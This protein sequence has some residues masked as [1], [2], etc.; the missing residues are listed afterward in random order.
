MNQLEDYVTT[1]KL[2]WETLLER[3]QVQYQ[4]SQEL[5]ER[6]VMAYSSPDRYYHNLKHIQQVLKT[7]EE[8]QSLANNFS[9]IQLAAWFHD[10]IYDS[11]AN[12]NEEKSAAH[13]V[14]ELN[15]LKI[16]LSTIETVKKIILTTKEHQANPDDIDSQILL[17]ADISILG[18]PQLVYRAYAEA[19]RQE[20][21][22]VADEQ[23]KISRKQVLEN[24]LQRERIY[25]TDK[26]F[27]ELEV[28][29]RCNLQAE[30]VFL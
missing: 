24:F 3:F 30:I 29:A 15:K 19:I 22:W 14:A 11:R 5:F 8:M 12:N 6:L 2:E 20:Y 26:L 18:S 16:P 13:A 9:A 21:A 27:S 1:L 17:D 28:Q 7:V 4:L 25:C 23:Y 10:L